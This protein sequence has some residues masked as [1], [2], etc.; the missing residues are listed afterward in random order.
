MY[1]ARDFIITP[2]GLVF[3]VTLGGQEE[4][5]VIACLRYV[6]ETSGLRKVDSREAA[7]LLNQSFPHYLHY[8]NRRDVTL[9]AV[10]VDRIKQ[11]LTPRKGLE[12]H[13]STP[14]PD[15]LVRRLVKLT[16][17]L[18][19]EGLPLHAMGVTGSLLAGTW[20]RDSDIDLVVYGLEAFELA[21]RAIRHLIAQD[22][23]ETPSLP[24]WETT[25]RR[26][27]CD[28]SFTD[29]L[30]HEQRKFNKGVIDGTKF[31]LVLVQE[32]EYD[33][34][35]QIWHKQGR[36][37]IRATVTDA[38]QAFSNPARYLLDHPC[39][40]LALSFTA[41]YVGQAKTGERVEI[42]GYH[43][44]THSGR[45]RVV[46]GSSREAPGEYIKVIHN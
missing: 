35:T 44:L 24:V 9:Q 20:H 18:T 37:K 26:R 11:H 13:L 14:N 32:G 31:D 46:V 3:A 38:S 19:G 23:L 25:W 33:V 8:S 41:T 7:D 15:P 39:I 21:R 10:S 12:M 5:R 27:G 17:L 36:I 1:Q 28:L 45:Q 34:D 6:P 29:Y 43:E 40:P 16:E 30:W 4:G 42:S 22:R 2:E